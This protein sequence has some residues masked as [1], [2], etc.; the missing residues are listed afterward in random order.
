M[1]LLEEPLPEDEEDLPPRVAEVRLADLLRLDRP[2]LRAAVRR[3]VEL[4][5]GVYSAFGNTP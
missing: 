5:E 1:S 2:W 3:V 4:E